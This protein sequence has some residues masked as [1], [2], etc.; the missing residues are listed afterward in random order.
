M[1][2]SLLFIAFNLL[3]CSFTAAQSFLEIDRIRKIQIAESN[4]EDVRKIFSDYQSKTSGDTDE[5]NKDGLKINANYSKGKCG[6]DDYFDL[7][8]AGGKASDVGIYLKNPVKL[9]KIQSEFKKAGFNISQFVKER[10]YNDDDDTY[11]YHN[12]ESGIGLESYRGKVDI[13]FLM[14][15]SKYYSLMCNKEFSKRLS[16]TASIFDTPIEERRAPEGLP[17]F[18]NVTRLV[19]SK[20]EIFEN[21]QNFD[22]K[23]NLN[24]KESKFV[25]VAISA[26]NPNKY[27]LEYIYNVTGGKII[28]TGKKVLWDLSDVKAGTYE[29]MAAADDGCG[30][31]GAVQRKT[32]T[33]K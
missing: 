17:Q 15:P 2:K 9:K 3:F 16:S 24:C 11:V 1:K 4:S 31:C 10:K 27:S 18:V 7:D 32:V 14:P 28:G 5:F 21:C 6:D 33:V 26:T 12:K 23:Q 20:T 8:I 19:L 30:I 13:I 29:I 25:S 22:S